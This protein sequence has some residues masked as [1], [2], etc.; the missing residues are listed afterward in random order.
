ME[1]KRRQRVAIYVLVG[2]VVAAL[3]L[4]LLLWANSGTPR[5]VNNREEP[6]VTN[7]P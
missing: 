7:S 5:D 3:L 4:G 2:A 1:T 6:A